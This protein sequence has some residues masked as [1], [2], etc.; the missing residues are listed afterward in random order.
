MSNS[1]NSL[2]AMIN[3]DYK[4]V[5]FGKGSE[6]HSQVNTKYLP[7]HSLEFKTAHGSETDSWRHQASIFRGQRVIHRAGDWICLLCQNHN[8]SF[9]TICNR[10]KSQSKIDN[11]QQSLAY[12][13]SVQPIPSYPHKLSF[14]A[15]QGSPKAFSNGSFQT[16]DSDHC[17]SLHP[18]SQTQVKSRHLKLSLPRSEMKDI[19]RGDFPFERQLHFS[20]SDDEDLDEQEE[21]Q[22]SSASKEQ[23]KRILGFLNF[24]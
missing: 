8:Y 13:Q 7:F 5:Q 15:E 11:M 18:S 16:V 17:E 23:Q 21:N 10:C 24:D 22:P 20:S 12:Y 9:R 3:P 6:M 14:L 4:P 19:D 1:S 2:L